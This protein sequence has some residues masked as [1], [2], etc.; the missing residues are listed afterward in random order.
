MDKTP[1]SIV[2]RN[3]MQRV[4][5]V[6]IVVMVVAVVVIP[7]QSTLAQGGGVYLPLI[8]NG[9]AGPQSSIDPFRAIAST[10]LNDVA[11]GLTQTGNEPFLVMGAQSGM[12]G[13]PLYTYLEDDEAT[14]QSSCDGVCAEAWPA[15][16]IEPT[17]TVLVAAEL[18]GALGAVQRA[19][20]TIQVTYN[21]WPLYRYI[22]DVAAADSSPAAI[23]DSKANGHG[24]DGL[25]WR[26]EAAR[27]IVEQ[28][29]ESLA[30]STSFESSSSVMA[31]F[32]EAGSVLVNQP[33]RDTWHTVELHQHYKQPV[34]IVQPL[35]FEDG[36]PATVR[37]RDVTSHSFQFKID[38]WS[39][40][41]GIH[42]AESIDYIV[43]E[44]G[45]HRLPN[46]GGRKVQAGIVDADHNWSKVVFD[47]PFPR[48]PVVFSQTQSLNDDE[49]IVTRQHKVTSGAFQ[50]RIQESDAS[51]GIHAV[52]QVGYL[53]I[54]SGK[55]YL[56][57]KSIEVGRTPNKVTQAQYNLEFSGV[58]KP[59]IFL[60]AMQTTDGRDAAT[61]RYSQLSETAVTVFVEEEQSKDDE[62][63]HTTEAIGYI[64]MG[65]GDAPP[66]PEP[67]VKPTDVVQDPMPES[68][69]EPTAVVPTPMPEP[70]SEPDGQTVFIEDATNN[71]YLIE[72][73]TDKRAKI[74][75]K[76][77][78][79]SDAITINFATLG[80]I[81]PTRGSASPADYIIRDDA[82][83]VLTDQISF[84]AGQSTQTI[85]VEIVADEQIEVPEML[86]IQLTAGNGYSVHAA[87]S[88]M[89]VY[90]RDDK[91]GVT[92]TSRIFF[93]QMEPEN[94]S[95]TDA[96]GWA[97]IRLSND[98]NFGL[99]SV[100]FSDLT[101]AETAAHVHYA[102]P[103]SGPIV[104]SLP[105]GQVEDDRWDIHAMHGSA[106]DQAM[107]DALLAGRL[108]INVHSE[109]YLE[110]EI[111]ATMQ[112]T[113]SSPDF[114]PPPP[115][116]PIERLTGDDL[117]RDILRF[118]TQ[119]SFGPTIESVAD[120]EARVDR[121]NGNRIRAYDEWIDEQ[122]KLESPSML[123]FL[124]A[125][126]RGFDPGRVND[127]EPPNEARTAR[128]H[129]RPAW[130]TTAVYGKAQLRERV[131]F[132]LSE[133]FVISTVNNQV[134]RFPWR[135]ASYDDMLSENAFGYYKKLLTDVS[136]HPAMGKYLSHL[137]NQKTVNEG[138]TIVS[139][140]DENYAREVMQLFSI[141]LVM[142][143]PDGS[144]QLG[145]DGLPT[146][147]YDQSDITGLA[148][149]FTGWSHAVQQ[150]NSGRTAGS[151][152]NN[153]FYYDPWIVTN[154][155]YYW[156]HH[157][158]PM[159]NFAQFHDVGAKTWLGL[160]MPA[161]RDGYQELN[162]VMSVLSTH[163]NTSVLISRRL[164][165][166]LVTSNPS[167]G[168]LYRVAQKFKET[169]GNLGAVIKAILLDPEARNLSMLGG[170]G[171][172]KLKEPLLQLV[173]LMR[174]SKPSM[175]STSSYNFERLRN[176]GYPAAQ[177]NLFE[178]GAQILYLNDCLGWCELTFR[179]APLHSPTVFNY[180][181]PDYA[182]PGPMSDAGLV[183][184]ELQLL[185]EDNAVGI[186]NA[187][188]K[189]TI[190][191]DGIYGMQPR[192]SNGGGQVPHY[193][194]R[195]PQWMANAYLAVMDTN[196]NGRIEPNDASFDNDNAIR[197]ASAALVDLADDY[198]CVG[199]LK[200]NATGNPQ[201][202]AREIIITGVNDALAY[203]DHR[204]AAKAMEALDSRI[205]EAL[206]LVTSA[207][208]CM[209]ME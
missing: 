142:L 197:A 97:I 88:E 111:R 27:A 107:L 14:G 132:A 137:R 42:A 205:R 189:L 192:L 153:N 207:P 55:A 152:P 96:T 134:R 157:T 79:G 18:D 194:Y 126:M 110:G 73:N 181:S 182:P 169:D 202:D 80:H 58:Y 10:D 135:P 12:A 76:R 101:S 158:E 20:G 82:G 59:P 143:H 72:S 57:G 98:N 22:G 125:N 16:I 179:Q 127:Q 168:Y 41:D 118:L 119:A 28:V 63:W 121:Y 52:E 113:E 65:S 21:G 29:D 201:T 100:S 172:G 208:Q 77:V 167:R 185:D 74:D 78:G 39:Y 35:S 159:K 122:M 104:H 188:Q 130:Y 47:V 95:D 9:A 195:Q 64:V 151:Q 50:L 99:I 51:D 204:D 198:L 2:P 66:M 4:I 154:G 171:S 38:E 43:I 60:A 156:P 13:M 162:D 45:I 69:V 56:G 174:F 196:G 163:P 136:R 199:R 83:A 17:E 133:I 25:W 11:I 193:I 105:L 206:Y 200:A 32:A 85:W 36:S 7:Q 178:R 150:I 67:T 40:L 175:S 68:T 131:A 33:S 62:L 180:F 138:G 145:D 191:S 129:Y 1:R 109:K 6:A 54:S 209:L 19:D 46:S 184:P 87:E 90:L 147:T 5:V 24:I 161:G 120:L 160:Q 115:A 44:S 71:H 93:G 173:A 91:V 146:R 30:A 103:V 141:G 84:K 149:V 26:A 117:R 190:T 183:A 31:S 140:P 203:L 23:V 75:I 34:V 164:I 94:G 144:L 8:Q 92:E 139:R 49:V 170:Q 112:L 37:V 81:S 177:I 106:T 15:F 70:T 48:Q 187:V 3:F 86:R 128:T 166:R 114:K 53:A 89:K 123:E 148:R 61:V 176:F 165:Q 155:S 186:Y 116:E 108:Y 102:S 124:H